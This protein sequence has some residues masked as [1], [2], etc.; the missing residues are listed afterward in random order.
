VN[1]RQR[2]GIKGIRKFLLFAEAA[3]KKETFPFGVPVTLWCSERLIYGAA[4]NIV[5]LRLGADVCCGHRRG[6]YSYIKL[7]ITEIEYDNP[8]LY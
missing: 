4:Q 2:T 7:E 6:N 1:S 8:S 3:K 5:C